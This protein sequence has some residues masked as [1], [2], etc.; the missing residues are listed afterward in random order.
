MKAT[1]LLACAFLAVSTVAADSD[2]PV[3]FSDASSKNLVA[4]HETL[5]S[6]RLDGVLGVPVHDVV[7]TVDAIEVRIKS[8]AVFLEPALEGGPVGAFFV[9][10]ATAHFKPAGDEQRRQLQ[11]WFGRPS[12]DG[13]PITSGYFLTL[14]GSDLLA[15]LGAAGTPSV[16]FEAA[17]SYVEAKHALRQRGVDAVT[18]FLNR[19]GASR[20]SAFAIL[21]APGIRIDRSKSALLML[22]FDPSQQ[23]ETGIEIYGHASLA[24][25]LPWKFLF[26]TVSAQPSAAPGFQPQ[27]ADLSYVIDLSLGFGMDTATQ[28]TTI[29]LRRRAGVRALRF[30]LTSFMQVE[31]VRAGS[32]LELPFLQWRR[33]GSGNDLDE[34]LLVDLDALPAPA[35]SVTLTVTSAGGLFEPFG[36]AY[37]LI[38][39]DAWYPNL[40]D[41][42]SANYELRIA[43]PTE[44]TAVAPGRLVEETAD[45]DK[46]HYV[47]RTSRPQK[48]S[49]L[50][51]GKFQHKSG[52]ADSTKIEAYAGK[53]EKNLAYGVTELQ[54]I[55]KVYNRLFV[56]LELETLR[57]ATAPID[58][59][60]GFE[61]FLLLSSDV[62]FYGASSQS[63]VFRAH[64]VAHQWWGN[65]VQ[66]ERWPR[67]RWLSE[68]FAEYASM[69][70]HRARFEDSRKTRDAI[71]Q[72]W[73]MP[74]QHA[75]K[76]GSKDLRGEVRGASVEELWSLLD[77]RDNVYTKGPMVLQMLRYMLSVKSGND[78][79]FWEIL[80]TFLKD[81][82]GK[83]ASTEDFIA[84][85]QRVVGTDLHWFWNQWLLRTEIPKVRWTKRLE[86]KDGKLLLT[87][88]AEQIDTEFTL[89]IPVY[90]HFGGGKI[91]SQPLVMKGRSG[92]AQMLLPSEPKDVTINDN[93]EALI[94]IAP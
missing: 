13:E 25:Q 86:P 24:E 79:K 71:F 45:D 61:G 27:G 94:E 65:M 18:A 91:A 50:Y 10:E 22:R 84:V 74:L 38:D 81:F 8:G 9:G 19:D 75:Q 55:V 34:T 44:R 53:D 82:A 70:Y 11:F 16:P 14:R 48:A 87:V 60:R 30:A 76:S 89:I 52:E 39:E 32:G 17:A 15:Q 57:V 12:L 40:S 7:W 20:G 54:N 26:R 6:P 4:L 67:D 1:P 36:D 46:R 3:K 64:E 28:K 31:S 59:G 90:V 69:E 80:R 49:S 88:E 93:W 66:P 29:T 58:H 85:S 21:T 51:I 77:G 63:D 37:Y 83:S 41:V 47:F 78:D 73:M 56:P 2:W 35:E 92:K 72:Q 33:D 62:G 42:R 43:L 23:E 5:M 68:T